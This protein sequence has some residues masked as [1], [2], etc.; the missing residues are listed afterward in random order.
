MTPLARRPVATTMSSFS[1]PDRCVRVRG[2]TERRASRRSTAVRSKSWVARSW[3][4]PTSVMRR[5]ERALARGGDL[6]DLAEQALL[7]CRSRI[8]M[9]GG[10]AALDVADARRPAG[11]RRRPAPTRSPASTECGDR[12]LHHRG[13]AR[14]GQGERDVLVVDGRHGHHGGVD[15]GGDERVDVGQDRQVAGDAVACPRR[16]RR[17]RRAPC[18]GVARMTRAWWRP[19]EPRPMRPHPQVSRSS[20][21]RLRDG[22]D[23]RRRCARGR[24]ASAR[25]APAARCTSA[26]ARSVSGRSS[27]GA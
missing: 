19:I 18:P 25:G 10:V 8:A 6:V 27:P 1:R 13:D 5:R 12:L 23:G 15:A 22:V 24:P 16:G 20:R 14:R 3:T 26:A 4:T 2:Q 11:A 7:R 21:T 9:H 17:R